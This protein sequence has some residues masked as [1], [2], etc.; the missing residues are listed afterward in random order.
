[1][2]KPPYP[3]YPEI[4]SEEILLRKIKPEE[5]SELL[6]I[7]FYDGKQAKSE[8]E[9]AAMLHRIENDYLNGESIH[10]GI[11]ERNSGKIVGTCGYYRGFKDAAGE[12]GC[13]LLPAYRGKGLMTEAVRLAVAFGFRTIG[14]QKVFAVTSPENFRM[15][16]LLERLNFR[17]T[18]E[19]GEE[20]HFEILR[21]GFIQH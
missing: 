4:A 13:I 21:K 1:M 3:E 2:K 12:L 6:I 9:A 15:I 16:K 11:E 17:K 19:V 5:L 18:K 8:T 7:S 14:L 10:W 20:V